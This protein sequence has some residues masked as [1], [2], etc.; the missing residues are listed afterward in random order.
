MAEV[1]V[2]AEGFE[3]PEGPVVLPDGSV[4][5]CEIQG[6]RITRVDKDGSK[7][8]GLNQGRMPNSAPASISAFH[9]FT[10]VASSDGV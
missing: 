6:Q 1:R 3:F 8:D 5:V 4:A 2:L 10:E 9:I 7:I